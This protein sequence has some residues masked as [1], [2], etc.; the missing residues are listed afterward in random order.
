M[1][2]SL[3]ITTRLIERGEVALLTIIAQRYEYE[4]Y[5]LSEFVLAL[6]P[7]SLVSHHNMA[8]YGSSSA[9]HC[10]ESC[11][12]NVEEVLHTVLSLRYATHIQC[13]TELMADDDIL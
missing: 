12:D 11:V 3:A 1:H 13:D 7:N 6:A 2:S 9:H 8:L 4:G 5:L 10:T